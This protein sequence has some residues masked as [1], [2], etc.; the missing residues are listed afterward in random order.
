[1]A[2]KALIEKAKK[3]PKFSVRK[4]TRCFECG[5]S[6]AVFRKYLLCRMCIR[7]FVYRGYLPGFCK[8]SW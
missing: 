5:R 2:R 4:Y 8:I 7:S 6:R 1:M 3:E